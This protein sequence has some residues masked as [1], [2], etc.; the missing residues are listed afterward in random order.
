M[1]NGTDPEGDEFWGWTRGKDQRM[2]EM[3]PIGY[4]ITVGKEV[5][6]DVSLRSKGGAEDQT[7]MG[8]S[9]Q[10]LDTASVLGG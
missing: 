6:F 3:S 2:V 7:Y 10:K 9:T 5:L 8:W 4:G 1:K